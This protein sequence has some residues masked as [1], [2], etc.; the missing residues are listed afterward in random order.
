MADQVERALADYGRAYGDRTRIERELEAVR[1]R[2]EELVTDALASHV[3]GYLR[4]RALPLTFAIK[5]TRPKGFS[6]VRGIQQTPYFVILVD[7]SWQLIARHAHGLHAV[8][9]PVSIRG[10]IDVFGEDAL[11]CLLHS[12]AAA[13]RFAASQ[14]VSTP[15]S[16]ATLPAVAG[17]Q[18]RM[19]PHGARRVTPRAED[20]ALPGKRDAT[21]STQVKV[22]C[23]IRR[24]HGVEPGESLSPGASTPAHQFCRMCNA[25]LPRGR[26]D[27]HMSAAHGVFHVHPKSAAAGRASRREFVRAS[28]PSS[29]FRPVRIGVSL[30]K[31]VS[32]GGPLDGSLIHATSAGRDFLRETR[33]ERNLVER[34]ESPHHDRDK[35]GR[36]SDA[37]AVE[38]MDDDSDA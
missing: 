29:P 1:T 35:T 18:A 9:T 3:L 37:P 12:L 31:S 28:S 10:F 30:L 8:V 36:F 27:A 33:L 22:E 15:R 11:C 5:G 4:D 21:G 34:A 26:L 13:E 6:L 16:L 20:G 14:A 23:C 25:R 7:E 24:G 38:R 17:S 2:L 19:A 32:D